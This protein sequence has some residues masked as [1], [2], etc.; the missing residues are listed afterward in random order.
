MSKYLVA[1]ATLIAIRKNVKEDTY[2]TDGEI[3]NQYRLA[4]D[5]I[6]SYFSKEVFDPTDFDIPESEITQEVGSIN[7]RTREKRYT[8]RSHVRTQLFLVMIDKVLA[9]MQ[10][11]A[12]KDE[13][14]QIGFRI[15][16]ET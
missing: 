11:L 15:S 12:P 7:T 8:G 9:Y 1:Y 3:I 6:A 10:L 13:K 16:K 14:E 4:L 2:W 5:H